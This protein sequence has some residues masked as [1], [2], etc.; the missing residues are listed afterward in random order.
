MSQTPL[1][2]TAESTIEVGCAEFRN[3]AA[4]LISRVSAGKLRAVL[5]KNREEHVATLTHPSQVRPL[6]PV[7]RPGDVQAAA[8]CIL[9]LLPSG[10]LDRAYATT[11]V[12]KA[13]LRSFAGG[14]ITLISELL[15]EFKASAQTIGVDLPLCDLMISRA[16]DLCGTIKVDFSLV[17]GAIWALRSG[18]DM[19]YFRNQVALS[20]DMNEE[21]AWMSTALAIA[22]TI[23]E[24]RD[25]ETITDLL[26]VISERYR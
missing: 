23:D 26:E 4:S 12:R 15:T 18:Y 16:M 5:I 22:L 3:S 1:S 11:K 10:G 7:F 17:A 2:E 13:G 21:L 8:A 9:A 24:A 6:Q 19:A 25:R 14:L 20:V